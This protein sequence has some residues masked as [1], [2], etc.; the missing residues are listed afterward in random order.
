MQGCHATEHGVHFTRAA[1]DR[2][3]VFTRRQARWATC[4]P[5]KAHFLA[6]KSILLHHSATG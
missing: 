4:T 2:E 1:H 5:K 6:P 3:R